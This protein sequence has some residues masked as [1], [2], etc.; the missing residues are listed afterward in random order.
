M[1]A[2]ALLAAM[3]AMVDTSLDT[4]ST[5]LHPSMEG[6]GQPYHLTLAMGFKKITTPCT[7][8]ASRCTSDEIMQMLVESSKN[9]TV[10]SG[11]EEDLLLHVEE[12]SNELTGA[13]SN[14][15]LD[16]K[17][18]GDEGE[19]KPKENEKKYDICFLV[20]DKN[21]KGPD[22]MITKLVVDC[23]WEQLNIDSVCQVATYGCKHATRNMEKGRL[24]PIYLELWG[25]KLWRYAILY[26]KGLVFIED[27][28][29]RASSW[30]RTSIEDLQSI[31]SKQQA[32]LE[33][34]FPD[35]VYPNGTYVQ[36]VLYISKEKFKLPDFTIHGNGNHPD[37]H[38]FYQSKIRM[39]VGDKALEWCVHDVKKILAD[40]EEQQRKMKENFF[41]S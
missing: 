38:L 24:C 14:E 30:S 19:E 36:G 6:G 40:R 15:S 25:E 37:T 8:G 13:E 28:E 41:K 9:T 10:V 34:S 12:E 18:E 23:K 39:I 29:V 17:H 3:A 5:F 35:A 1:Q 26:P 4:V 20:H 11:D 33:K 22:K 2:D 31:L 16:L 7:P 32:N 27:E 21:V